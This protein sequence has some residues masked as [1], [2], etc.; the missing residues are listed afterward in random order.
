LV[1]LLVFV[2]VIAAVVVVF[3]VVIVVVFVVA[4]IVLIIITVTEVLLLLVV[5]EIVLESLRSC[6]AVVCEWCESCVNEQVGE[7]RRTSSSSARGPCAVDRRHQSTR[8]IS[9]TVV[10]G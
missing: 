2:V 1:V 10:A 5:G 3:V 6:C 9:S 8:R 7:E 4:C